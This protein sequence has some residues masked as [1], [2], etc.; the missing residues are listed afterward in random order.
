LLQQFKV[1]REVIKED[2]LIDRVRRVGRTLKS[3]LENV[4]A[5]KNVTGEGTQLYLN[6]VDEESAKKLWHDLLSNGVI[7][8]LNGSRGVSI[9]PALI[10]DEHHV[11]QFV[12]VL[13]RLR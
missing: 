4:S 8:K 7:T 3:R 5:V 12:D 1:I 13:S 11:D 6:T 2:K 9:K 10:L